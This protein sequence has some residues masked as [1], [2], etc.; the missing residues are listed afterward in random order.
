MLIN[1]I[2]STDVET[3][4]PDTGIHEVAKKMY[5]R[6]CGSVI[7]VKGGRLVGMITD[8]DLAIR[9]IAHGHDPISTT[10]EKVMSPEILHCFETDEVDHIT[11]F[12]GKN[13]IRRMPVLNAQKNLVGIVSLGDMA[14]HSNHMLC[15]EVLGQICHAA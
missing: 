15:G 11:K 12:M 3:V 10:A 8:R 2:M 1:E 14:S 6:D 7:V 13:K 9:C 4:T 5:Q